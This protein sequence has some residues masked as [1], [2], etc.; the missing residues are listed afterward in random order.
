MPDIPLGFS[1]LQQVSSVPSISLL[2]YYPVNIKSFNITLPPSVS[3]T[4]LQDEGVYV[5]K[6]AYQIAVDNGF[7]GTESEW[8]ASLAGGEFISDPLAYY[9]LAKS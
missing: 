7:V 1:G 2:T 4:I 5:G 8:L 6:S 9:I 3:T